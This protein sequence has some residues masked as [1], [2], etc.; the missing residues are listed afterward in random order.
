MTELLLTEHRDT[1]SIDVGRFAARRAERVQPASLAVVVASVLLALPSWSAW[2]GSAR[3][4][5]TRSGLGLHELARHRA[6]Y[7]SGHPRH[8]TARPVLVVGGRAAVLRVPGAALAVAP[9]APRSA[10]GAVGCGRRRLVDRRVLHA[11]PCR[12]RSASR[13]R[14]RVPGRRARHRHAARRSRSA[15]RALAGRSLVHRHQYDHCLRSPPRCSS[16][17]SCS[18]T[19]RRRGCS[20]VASCS[21]Q[22]CRRRCCT[23][24]GTRRCG[25][26]CTGHARRCGSGH[27]A[28]RCTSSTGRSASSSHATRRCA[29]RRSSWSPSSS[30]SP[31]PSSFTA[32]W[33]SRCAIGERTP[34]RIGLRDRRRIARR[35][36]AGRHRPSV[37]TEVVSP[38]WS[39]GLVTRPGR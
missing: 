22:S 20:R 11:V 34:R 6:G 25:Q 8:R 31:R 16:P 3:D 12:H 7:R 23:P 27:S 39:P 29:A 14:N 15:P 30:R 37:V 36:R 35:Q 17:G 1:G 28:T 26:P 21:W 10:T 9:P 13:V 2:N 33:R 32:S 4:R 5:C 24:R 18:P 38:T 19:S